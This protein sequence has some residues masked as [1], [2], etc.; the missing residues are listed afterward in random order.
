M[1]HRKPTKM[2]QREVEDQKIE[3]YI[4]TFEYSGGVALLYINNMMKFSFM[5]EIEFDV[6]NLQLQEDSLDEDS[7]LHI[8]L[9]PNSEKLISL[10]IV[11]S[12]KPYS[13]STKV[14]YYLSTPEFKF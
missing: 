4:K 10:V 7:K 12:T 9:E 1:L 14:Q 8:E 6:K 11:D 5:Q 3:V 2:R 13:F